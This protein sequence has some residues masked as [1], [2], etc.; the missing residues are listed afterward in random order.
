MAVTSAAT[1][2]SNL[3]PYEEWQSRQRDKAKERDEDEYDPESLLTPGEQEQ[4]KIIRYCTNL[5]D[6]ARKARQ[7]FDT[8]DICWDLFIGNVWPN[9]WPTWRAKITINKIRAFIT[10]MQAIMTDNKPRISVEPLVPGSE[11]AAD[12]LRKLV[13]RDWDE[14]NMQGKLSTFVLFGLI[15]GT[16]FMKITYDPFANAGR[17]AHLAEPVAPY[18][19]YTNR[20]AKCVED[21]EYLIHV[22][23]V[24]LGWIRRNFPA[25]AETVRAMRG[26][27]TGVNR[28]R[29]RDFLRE[30]DWNETSRIV[31]AQNVNVNIV[32][33]MT[34]APN[35]QYMEGDGDEIEVCEYWLR[36]DTLEPYQR[37]KIVNGEAKWEPDLNDDGTYKLEVSGKKLSIS[38]I[39]GAM[40]SV[41]LYTPKMKPVME[42]AW[43][44]MFPNGRL[45]LIA[46][47]RVLLRDI[48]NPFQTDG[49]PFAMW[50][51]YDVGSFWGQGEP[52]ALKDCSVAINKI[53]SQVYDILEKTGNPQYKLKKGAG[54]NYRK[55]T[56]KPGLLIPMDEMD[57]LQPLEKPPI[58]KEFLE[59]FGVIRTRDGRDMRCER[60]G[61]RDDA[62]GQHG[63]RHD[64]SVAG[65]RRRAD[66]PQGS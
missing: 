9:R 4:F 19:I 51:D 60:F 47:G 46:G 12:L 23:D 57:G 8:F 31:S 40:F 44:P 59:L 24:T 2:N 14:N 61:A 34:S 21:A 28:D 53:I 36:D 32:G 17:G 37:Q 55:I 45:V 20:T 25:K 56:N 35:P 50:K 58:P 52:I 42:Q 33:P 30:G 26:V 10:F 3:I 16:G 6:E 49:F 54:V 29:D 27:R 62:G 22:E 15:W 63:V 66:S 38:E 11:D 13:D 64:G 1:A 5:Y 41:D 39:D 7:P 48:P 65:V 18:R 43:R